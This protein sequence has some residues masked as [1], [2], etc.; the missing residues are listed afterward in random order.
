ME[1]LRTINDVSIM[2]TPIKEYGDC[3]IHIALE[4]ADTNKDWRLFKYLL[5]LDRKW[6]LHHLKMTEP[7]FHYN[8]YKLPKK[9]QDDILL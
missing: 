5:S 4:R 1:I 3:S 2:K 6:L 8:V 9:E 7:I